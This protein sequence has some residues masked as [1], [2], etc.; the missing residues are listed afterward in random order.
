MPVKSKTKKTS[1]KV[2]DK[3]QT[4]QKLNNDNL[5]ES[6]SNVEN[7]AKEVSVTNNESRS[8]LA[9]LVFEIKK[10][11]D[12]D[13]KVTVDSIR[14]TTNLSDVPKTKSGEHLELSIDQTM[15]NKESNF[16]QNFEI[17]KDVSDFN[18][19]E[20]MSEND[21]KKDKVVMDKDLELG[22]KLT[23]SAFNFV[24]STNDS[25][26]AFNNKM[27]NFEKIPLNEDIGNSM[28]ASEN[29]SNLILHNSEEITKEENQDKVLQN[30]EHCANLKPDSNHVKQDDDVVS[31]QN[32]KSIES[33][34]AHL[35]H[36]DTNIDNLSFSDKLK[37]DNNNES[38]TD[39]KNENSILANEINYQQDKIENE[40]M[41]P[42]NK[43]SIRRFLAE[44]NGMFIS[45]SIVSA[46]LIT[47]LLIGKKIL[48]S[49]N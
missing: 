16:G 21:P 39:F 4:E 48:K 29:E 47:G 2:L 14:S 40:H 45:I 38:H 5:N 3:N 46:A 7:N 26:V 11:D 23:Y 9:D 1:K 37:D 32:N 35:N 31:T 28:K 8:P 12:E 42:N 44:N 27:M 13:I 17:S 10:E 20:Q 25:E 24:T 6:V 22:L 34:R 36:V 41:L 43:F 15:H 18:I 49:I 33:T 30:I 19:Q